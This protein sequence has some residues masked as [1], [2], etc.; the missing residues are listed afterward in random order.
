[1]RCPS[2]GARNTESAAWCTQCYATLGAQDQPAREQVA[3]P[4][5]ETLVGGPPPPPPPA[6]P[7]EAGAAGGRDIRIRGEEVEWRC[8]SCEGW[9]PLEAPICTVCGAPRAGFASDV[10]PTATGTPKTDQTTALLA[11]VVLPGLGHVLRGRV[12][13]GLA[14]LALWSLWGGGGLAVLLGSGGAAAAAVLLLAALL[15]WA[16]TLVDVQRLSTGRAPLATA[17][18]LAWSVVGVTI[19]LAL[20]ALAAATG[21]TAPEAASAAMDPDPTVVGLSS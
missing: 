14:R 11:S 12:G 13:T 21:A 2:C 9:S 6:D 16:V 7:A 8:A 4:E 10:S 5:N 3:P 19:V 20:F 17:R 1:M 15:L 18:V